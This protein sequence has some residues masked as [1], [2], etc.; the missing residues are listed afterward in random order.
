MTI[1]HPENFKLAEEFATKLEGKIIKEILSKE[2]QKQAQEKELVYLVGHSSTNN[3]HLLICGMITDSIN[4]TF[5]NHL[6][7]LILSKNGIFNKIKHTCKS[8]DIC[9]LYQNEYRACIEILIKI[10][11]EHNFWTFSSTDIGYATFY[12]KEDKNYL[13]KGIVFHVSELPETKSP[14]K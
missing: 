14:Y 8:P 9:D 4:I 11:T 13:P 1:K 3:N 5:H 6:F 12:L 2:Y 10:D 7:K